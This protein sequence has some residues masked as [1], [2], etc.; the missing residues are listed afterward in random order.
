MQQRVP[1]TIDNWTESEILI[2]G[3]KVVDRT[4]IC[5]MKYLVCGISLWLV[6]GSFMLNSEAMNHNAGTILRRY[7]DAAQEVMR[8]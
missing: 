6:I 4:L 7:G 1:I 5:K 8:T 2:Q 3:P